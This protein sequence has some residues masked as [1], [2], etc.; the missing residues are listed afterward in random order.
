MIAEMLHGRNVMVPACVVDGARQQGHEIV[1][2][3]DVEPA[4]L[5]SPVE[6]TANGGGVDTRGSEGQASVT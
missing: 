5:E 1:Q 3:N 4:R 2:M 6:I